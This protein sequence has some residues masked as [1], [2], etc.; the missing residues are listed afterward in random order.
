MKYLI[1]NKSVIIFFFTCLCLVTL[2]CEKKLEHIDITVRV[3]DSETKKPLK[4]DT[5]EIRIGK[6]SFPMR[7]YILVG[8]YISDSLG[9]AKIKI[10]KNEIHSVT[11][12]GSHTFGATE[13]RKG[14]LKDNDIIT[15]EIVPAEKRRIK[16]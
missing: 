8:K 4:N 13:F 12:R 9:E 15:V 14:E 6:S 10:Q 2:S 1:F 7:K 16:F 3:I 5:I 11:V